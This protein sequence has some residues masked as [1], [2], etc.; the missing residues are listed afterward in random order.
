MRVQFGVSRW[1]V[2]A[3]RSGEGCQKVATG[4]S[5]VSLSLVACG[6]LL[7]LP[8][9]PDPLPLSL[10]FSALQ[11]RLLLAVR[12]MEGRKLAFPKRVGASQEVFLGHLVP[13]SGWSHEASAL[14]LGSQTRK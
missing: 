10:S 5:T 3:T 7:D 14:I 13:T 6:K 11:M 4:V 2:T 1:G 9:S 12:Q 8:R